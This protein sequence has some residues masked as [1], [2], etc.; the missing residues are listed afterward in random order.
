M[1]VRARR[2]R[3]RE[4]NARDP[5]IELRAASRSRFGAGVGGRDCVHQRRTL[6][7][8]ERRLREAHWRRLDGRNGSALHVARRRP[9][10]LEALA[11]SGLCFDRDHA[12]AR[13]RAAGA[14]ARRHS[15]RGAAVPARSRA[16]VCA[17]RHGV[18][19]A[20]AASRR[21]EFARSAGAHGTREHDARRHDGSRRRQAGAI[22]GEARDRLSRS[23]HRRT[24]AAGLARARRRDGERSR[25]RPAALGS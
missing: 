9:R 18:P 6:S 7:V 14:P 15:R 10:D 4:R 12:D 16:P 1:G 8:S 13:R 22:A 21:T 3:E 23:A 2:S 20:R 17:A 24:S 19:G 5:A 11:R 25:G